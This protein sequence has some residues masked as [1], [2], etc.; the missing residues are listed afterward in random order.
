MKILIL[1][2]TGMLG[3]A[4]LDFLL[5]KN[6]DIT[7]PTRGELGEVNYGQYDY[8]INCIG[9]IKQKLNNPKEAIEINSVFPHMLSEKAPKAKIIQIATDCVFS[10]RDGLYLEENEHDALDIYGRTKSLGE[11]EAKNFFN[12]RTS[13]I[14]P[15]EDSFSLLEWFLSQEK[16]ATVDGYTNHLWNGITTL[17]FAKLC[18]TIIEGKRE[19]PNLLHFI[20]YDIVNKY[21]LLK[22]FAVKF[23]RE[24][25]RIRPF[26]ANFCNR[27][28]STRH[29][30]IVDALWGDMGYKIPPTIEEMINEL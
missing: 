2:F 9:I 3:S 26:R 15:S 19:I 20:P 5:T 22:L 4:V 11:V 27:V 12:I 14:G 30:Y 25:I 6:L 28:L 8:I 24:D 29:I 7:A 16:N 23:D 17:Q 21:K 1:G 13:I 18:Y 10:G